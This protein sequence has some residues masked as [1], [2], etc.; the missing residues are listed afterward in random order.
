M[1]QGR[2]VVFDDRRTLPPPSSGPRFDWP[3]LSRW[4]LI[5]TI[6][7]LVYLLAPVARCTW[8]AFRDTPISGAASE[9]PGDT[10]QVRVDRGRGFVAGMFEA[11]GD[12]YQRTPLPGQ[13]LW[14]KQ[15]LAVLGGA[16]LLTFLIGR[17]AAPRRPYSP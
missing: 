14:E 3:R 1:R 2:K 8:R 11:C 13:E 6:G 5:G 15:T 10:D 7:M 17:A 9:S 16:T 4:C 12:C